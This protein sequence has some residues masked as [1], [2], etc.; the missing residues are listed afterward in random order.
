MLIERPQQQAREGKGRENKQCY[1]QVTK[2]TPEAYSYAINNP[3]T[4]TKKKW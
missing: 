3:S 4:T 2:K 1:Q